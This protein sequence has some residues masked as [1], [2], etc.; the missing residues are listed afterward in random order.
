MTDPLDDLTE[1]EKEALRLL[2]AGHDAKS[3]G[4]VLGVSFHAVND[5]LRGARRKLGA[6]SSREAAL[7]LVQREKGA[8]QPLVHKPLGA[9]EAQ[10]M[11]NE[12]L[13]ADENGRRQISPD[14]RR[15]GFIIMSF[16]LFIAVT[17]LATGGSFTGSHPSTLDE[18]SG[19][20]EVQA[21]SEAGARAFLALFDSGDAEASYSAAGKPMRAAHS[22]EMW[23]LGIALRKNRG[24]VQDRVL[25]SINR[26][27]GQSEVPGGVVEVLVFET[28]LFGGDRYHERLVMQPE[29]GAW[30]VADYDMTR[31]EED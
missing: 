30:K 4:R 14:W 21:R 18:R 25:K 3:S 10:T 1:K 9:A 13:S 24:G 27:S 23:E 2:L 22:F 26:E 16:T 29:G 28:R 19:K 5:R 8:P 6:T 31:I 17:A 20:E 15:K 12:P 11:S 7:R